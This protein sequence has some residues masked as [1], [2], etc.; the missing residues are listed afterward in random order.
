MRQKSKVAVVELA[1]ALTK[2]FGPGYIP[3]KLSEE[4]SELAIAI[5]KLLALSK[6]YSFATE[7]QKKVIVANLFEEVAHVKVFINLLETDLYGN[8]EEVN[9]YMQE[10]YKRLETKVT[11][12][13]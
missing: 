3:H 6:G 10:R 7:E 5:H 2:R 11:C 8:P 13:E 12:S 9:K 1:G 4:C